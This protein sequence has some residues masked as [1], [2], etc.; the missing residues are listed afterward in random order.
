[1]Y[2]TL[3]WYTN[4]ISGKNLNCSFERCSKNCYINFSVLKA[5][6]EINI[7]KEIFTS[8]TFDLC[9]TYHESYIHF[10]LFFVD[11]ISFDTV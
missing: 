2:M 9:V 7:R 10:T 8:K 6:D 11:S 5:D 3:E 4:S 1:M